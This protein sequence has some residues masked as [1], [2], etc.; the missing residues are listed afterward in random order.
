MT[1]PYLRMAGISKSY[2]PIRALQGVDFELRAGEVMA[3]LGE[4]GAGKSTLVKALAGL[5]RP[6][7]GEIS[8]DGRTVE[9]FPPHRSEDAGI[10]V[11]QQELS[12]VPTMTAAENVFLGNSSTG[13]WSSPAQLRAR[14][15]PYLEQVG[16]GGMGDRLASSLTVAERQLVEVARLIARD[17]RILIFDEPT[18]ALADAEIHR[19][20][21]VVRR[22]S[23]EGRA[24]IYV[25]HRL[26]EV[27][28]LADRVTVFREGRG[29]PALEVSELDM[30]SLV[31]R[32][33]GRPLEKMYPPP[34]SG[35]GATVLKVDG[36]V[37]TGLNEPVSLRVRAGEILGLVG[38][39]GSGTTPLL[40][41]LAGVRHRDAGTV[42]LGGAPLRART[43]REA[44]AAG[45]AY[46]SGD[47]K[48][49]GL[50]LIRPV[51]ENLTAAGLPRITP[52]GLLSGRRQRSLAAEI[53]GFFRVD[54]A[55]LPHLA[56]TLS[57][58]NQQKVA[59]GKWLGVGPKVLLVDEPTR[60]VDVGARAEI[61]A[62]LRRL[63]EQGL[64]VVFASSDNQEVLGLA[65]TVAT[66]YRG[67]LVNVT[68]SD[69]VDPLD[70]LRDITHPRET[71]S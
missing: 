67:R 43:T 55:R 13:V 42:E 32:M 51:V 16:L 1:E 59:L 2:G 29:Q 10:A 48:L 22:L 23:G 18:A 54:R 30:D 63:A 65:D 66:F 25:T 15:Q 31:Q 69:Q 27:F 12:I 61:Y 68:A 11:V 24:I 28:E 21:D 34:S 19:V 53:A 7:S 58:G 6:D 57:G 64:A 4:N 70:V 40:E 44:I 17:A 46:C 50:F 14:A 9:L 8:V 38:Q 3:L 52:G 35:L 39:L 56:N 62:H 33:L 45:V 49:D 37:T 26:A 47:R 20:H 71:V 60:G 36:L 41:A 5:Q